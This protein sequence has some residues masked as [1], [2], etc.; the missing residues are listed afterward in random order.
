[1]KKFNAMLFSALLTIAVP[2][3]SIAA[4]VHFDLNTIIINEL[5]PDG[6]AGDTNADGTINFI[7][8]EFIELVNVTGGSIDISGYSLWESDL[9][10]ARHVFPSGTILNSYEPIV[11]FGG[12]VPNLPG[13]QTQTASN[14]DPGIAFG[15]G[16]SDATDRVILRDSSNNIVFDIEYDSTVDAIT[17]QSLTRSPDL[18]G[19]YVGH[20]SAQGSL[21][22]FSP[23]TFINGAPISAPVPIPS[24]VWLFGS[25][26]LGFIGMAKRKKA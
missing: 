9:G 13:I 8:D 24:A 19:S 25:G 26:L 16:L 2:I 22:S 10:T 11:I 17:D 5:L 23:G 3:S 7:Q 21:S 6:D 14:A 18:T 4:T 20:S 12:G 15:L 1:M